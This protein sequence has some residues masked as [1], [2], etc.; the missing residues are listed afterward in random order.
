MAAT[1]K[2]IAATKNML[3]SMKAVKMMGAGKRI[4]AAVEKLRIQEF[5]ASESYR[6]LLLYSVSTCEQPLCFPM[7]DV[8][9]LYS[10]CHSCT[11]TSCRFRGLCRR[12]CGFRDYEPRRPSDVQFRHTH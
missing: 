10:L 11:G 9:T 3:A 4:G 2:R 1:E 5:A 8:L 7:F 6:T 12:H